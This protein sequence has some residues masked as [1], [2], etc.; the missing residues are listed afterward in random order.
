MIK[1]TKAQKE[2][3]EYQSISANAGFCMANCA[4]FYNI[5][6]ADGNIIVENESV[7]NLRYLNLIDRMGDLYKAGITSFKIEGRQREIS[8][9]RNVVALANQKANEILKKNKQFGKR[10]SSGTSIVTFKPDLNKVFNRG[11]TELFIDGRKKENLTSKDVYGQYVGKINKQRNNIIEVDSKKEL[12]VGDRFLC[13]KEKERNEIVNIIGIKN[14]NKYEIKENINV[15]GRK[16]YRIVNA[17]AVDEIEKAFTYRYISVKLK[18][19]NIDKT[20]YKILVKDEDNIETFITYKKNLKANISKDVILKIFNDN[21]E[22][23]FQI[24]D[25]KSPKD[26]NLDKQDISMLQ[27]KIY[28]KQRAAREKARPKEK[29]KIKNDGRIKYPYEKLNSL[30]NV[31]NNRAKSFFRKHGVKEIEPAIE[32]TKDI[33]NRI[34]CHS[35]YCIKYEQGYCSKKKRKDTPKEPWYL[36]DKFGNKYK[37]QFDCDKCEMNILG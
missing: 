18:I 16:L 8:Y 22:Y 28:I 26:I 10:L 31:I 5:F 20:K 23:E 36:E 4:H 3:I 11:F 1:N 15:K 34:V 24:V 19:S 6:D 13:A 2:L 33:E 14:K 30:E 35:R 7:L 32:S 9:V 25:I 37:L 17:K 12:N 29:G 21:K 27:E